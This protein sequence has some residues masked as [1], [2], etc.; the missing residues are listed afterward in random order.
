[1]SSA[2]DKRLFHT[3]DAAR[4]IAALVV[5]IHHGVRFH[6][7]LF[8]SGFLA[9]DFFFGLSGFV[10]AHAYADRLTSGAISPR[11]FMRA[12]LVRLYP[13]YLLGLIGVLLAL[14]PDLPWSPVALL[15]K[16]PFALAMLP[17]PSLDAH[18]FIYS[19]NFPAW[20]IFFELLV[21]LFFAIFCRQLRDPHVR[22][23]VIIGSGAILAIQLAAFRIDQGGPTWDVF[24]A[25]FARV[26]FSFFLG[27]QVYEWH[28]RRAARGAKLHKGWSLVGLVVLVGCLV[29]PVN[30]DV[31][32]VS[33]FVV[34]PVL[35]LALAEAELPMGMFSGALQQLG[36]I[37]YALYMLHLA[38]QVALSELLAHFGI[39]DN[40]YPLLGIPLV[41][42][43][44]AA[45]WAADRWFDRP[46]RRKIQAL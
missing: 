45:S 43:M 19:F 4:G 38:F 15:G 44:I 31:E 35:I 20:S 12:R 1:M 23:T 22:W 3:L 11:G 40:R 30:A 10:L 37:S 46:L 42:A 36:V 9:V 6:G 14:A 17:S 29:A 18:G 34:F 5:A 33:I 27:M 16:L 2:T 13:L 7:Q 26:S 32:I 41:G 25:G 24:A 28:V 8:D 21:N 39:P